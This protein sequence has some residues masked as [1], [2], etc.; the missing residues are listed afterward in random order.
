MIKRLRALQRSAKLRRLYCFGDQKTIENTSAFVKKLSN[1]C[2]LFEES[3]IQAQIFLEAFDNIMFMPDNWH[4]G[5]NMLQSLHKLF[6]TDL[7]K[8]LR[9]ILGLKR[10]AKDVRSCYYQAL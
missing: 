2:L 4:A 5:M 6:W 1:R 7:L 8:S 3:S 10:M 9:D